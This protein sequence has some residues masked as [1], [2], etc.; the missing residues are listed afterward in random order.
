MI[1]IGFKI[2]QFFWASQKDEQKTA[3]RQAGTIGTLQIRYRTA[4]EASDT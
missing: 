1:W 4:C 2:I 3:D